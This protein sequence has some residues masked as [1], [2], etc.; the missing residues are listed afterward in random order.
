M[1]FLKNKIILITG[2][3]GTIG[4]SLIDL[5]LRNYPPKIIR[6]FSR[7]ETKQFQLAKQLSEHR[8]KLRF[9]IGN[10]RDKERLRKAMQNV[11]IVFHLA[12]LKHVG[13]CEYNPFEAIK[14]NVLGLQNV[15]EVCIENNVEKF[16][17]TSTDKAAS[18]SNTMGVTKLLG[19]KLVTTANYYK[20]NTNTI[21]Y[22]VRFGNVLGSRG[23]LI[24]LI[25]NQIKN[26][27]SITL[28]HKEMTRF[29]MSI[30]NAL[31]LIINTLEIAQ[32]GEVFV[33]KMD[34]IKI[35]NL[36]EVLI[37]YFAKI[38]DKQVE[39]ITIEE[40]GMFAGEKLYEELFTVEESERTY[41]MDKMYVIFPQITEVSKQ[42]NKEEYPNLIIT[43]KS[44]PFKSKDGP[45]LS[46]DEIT[47]F[48]NKIGIL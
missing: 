26:D 12:A 9:F 24:P 34:V 40:I 30:D 41:E 14:T 33:L 16:I 32:G 36:I 6:I 1:N 2:G 21:F 10:I 35:K 19:E 18:P 11:N 15:I 7:D 5:L 48:L 13:I 4:K 44:L 23:S 28:T 20:G 43:D 31:N 27:K 38:Y 39:K 37:K 45:F 8:D 3:S 47:T 42:I 29:I 17:F 22:S 46:K 25:E